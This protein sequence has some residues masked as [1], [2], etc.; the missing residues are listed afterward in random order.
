MAPISG[1][2]LRLKKIKI[3]K[4]PKTRNL[5]LLCSSPQPQA[6]LPSKILHK[7]GKQNVDPHRSHE[8]PA[9]NTHSGAWLDPHPSH[10]LTDCSLLVDRKSVV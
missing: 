8:L 3:H 10:W 9:G 4:I 5:N 2:A 6:E 1:Q 7:A